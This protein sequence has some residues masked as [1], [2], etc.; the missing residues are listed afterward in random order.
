MSGATSS[1]IA[2]SENTGGIGRR[3]GNDPRF[4]QTHTIGQRG[5]E[6]TKKPYE[7]I[8]QGNL[9]PRILGDHCYEQGCSASNCKNRNHNKV[10][11]VRAKITRANS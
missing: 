9:D 11:G 1:D 4:T 10:A 7:R 3:E 2:I 5:L 6:R 8:E